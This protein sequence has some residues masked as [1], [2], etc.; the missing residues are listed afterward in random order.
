MWDNVKRVS[1][2]ALAP[3]MFAACATS[4]SATSTNAVNRPIPEAPAV[5]FASDGLTRTVVIAESDH[6]IQTSWSSVTDSQVARTATELANL[7]GAPVVLGAVAGIVALDAKPRGRAA[8]TATG[9]SGKILPGELDGALAEE[10]GEQL[11]EAEIG[12]MDVRVQNIDRMRNVPDDAWVVVTNYT[13]SEDATAL[14][15]TAQLIHGEELRYQRMVEA[16]LRRRDMERMSPGTRGG[17]GYSVGQRNAAFGNT[18]RRRNS[19]LS[20]RPPARLRRVFE[21]HSDG[22]VLPEVG[23]LVSDDN[24]D[25]LESR[26]E[27]AL[28]LE[29]DRRRAAADA[30]VEDARARGLSDKKIAKAERKRDKAYSKADKLYTEGMKRARDG[31]LDKMERMVLGIAA[32]NTPVAPGSEETR[33]DR[34]LNNARSFFARAIAERL[35]GVTDS[36]P[37]DREPTH[38]ENLRGIMV[39]DTKDDGRQ[40]AEFF[41][42]DRA[43]LVVSYPEDGLGDYGRQKAKP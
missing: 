7:G 1:C 35:P 30:R 17:L 3:L 20:K 41:K 25:T 18:Y 31:E 10:L 43:G 14:R 21:H 28:G 26:I 9:V 23:E 36:D 34:A 27:T 32:W 29:R 8:R 5:D 11:V 16:E 4:P 42:G 2:L 13:L 15:S 33:L 39:L 19:R 38:E 6:A 24:R 22:I 37:L 12:E 40:T